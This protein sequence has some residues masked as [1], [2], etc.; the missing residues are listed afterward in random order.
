MDP[1]HRWR[2]LEQHFETFQQVFSVDPSVFLPAGDRAG[3]DSVLN[4]SSVAEKHFPIIH[5][6]EPDLRKA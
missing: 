4:L 3:I 5:S 2:L 1:L 6:S